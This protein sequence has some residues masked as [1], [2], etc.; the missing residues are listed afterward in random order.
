MKLYKKTSDAVVQYNAAVSL[1]KVPPVAMCGIV[2]GNS[3]TLAEGM[4]DY[5]TDDRDDI[6]W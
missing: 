4:K 5:A 6:E 1:V 3:S 2:A